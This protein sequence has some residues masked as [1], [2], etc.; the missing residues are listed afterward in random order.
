VLSQPAH[1]Y[2]LRLLAASEYTELSAD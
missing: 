2:T 1:P